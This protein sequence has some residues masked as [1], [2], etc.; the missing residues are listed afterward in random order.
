M[1]TRSKMS[2]LINESITTSSSSSMVVYMKTSKL[3]SESIFIFLDLIELK[4]QTN[5]NIVDQLI[6]FL[7][8]SGFTENYL[9][10]NWI[11]F[12]MDG[13]SVLLGRKKKLVHA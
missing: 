11:T 2:I 9:T 10:E 12:V 1:K 13:A 5:S 8:T 3:F 7:H 6:K 4:N